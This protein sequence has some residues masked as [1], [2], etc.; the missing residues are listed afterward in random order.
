MPIASEH[1]LLELLGPEPKRDWAHQVREFEIGRDK[2]SRALLWSMRTGKS[3]AVIDKFCYQYGEGNIEGAVIIAPN[4]VHLNWVINEIPKWSWPE[5]G[6]HEVFGWE[7]PKRADFD[8]IANLE[9]LLRHGGMKWFCLNMEALSHRDCVKALRRF[10][11]AC[12]VDPA[13]GYMRCAMAISEAHHFG[14]AGVKRTRL[15]RSLANKMRFV[16]EETGTPILNSPLRWYSMGKILDEAAVPFPRYE[17][18]VQHFAEI[19]VDRRSGG[20]RRAYKK[21]AAY[22][23]MDELREIMKP[24]CSVVLRSDVED[25]PELLRTERV[26]AM[27]ERQRDKYLEMVSRHLVEIG[28]DVVTAIDGGARMI[29]LQQILNGYV[30][31]EDDIIDVDPDA[32]IYQALV[33]E[34]GGTLP[35]KTIVWCR[36]REDIR[37]CCTI[38]KRAKFK[39]LEFHGGVPT[40]QREGIRLAFQNDPKYTVLVG[41]PGAGGEGRDFSAADAII[42]FSSTP[43]AIHVTQAEERGTQLKGHPVS[44]IRFRTRGTVD[45][46]NWAIVDGKITLAETVSGRGLRDLLMATDV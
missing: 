22:K 20:R 26:I 37:R 41:Q 15:A 16:T 29:K 14:H 23:N 35:G 17:P 40:G 30:K 24:W 36:F 19:E 9:R 46:R 2:R 31:D 21:I 33:E 12:G 3:K 27:S 7:T 28:D 10:L 38:L 32:P 45:D 8:V 18:F 43:N 5:N 6:H 25:M 1:E 44:I 13:T 42:F 4:G 11:S 39:V 34:V